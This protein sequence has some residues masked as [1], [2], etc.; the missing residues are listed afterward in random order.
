MTAY[1]EAKKKVCIYV[2]LLKTKL[3]MFNEDHV[4]LN[5]TETLTDLSSLQFI[6]I[7]YVIEITRLLGH[8]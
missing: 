3:F 4:S 2:H 5:G 7:L 1:T 6:I 8:Y